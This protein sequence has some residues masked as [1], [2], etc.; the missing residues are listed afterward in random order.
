[1]SLLLIGA[2]LQTPLMARN[3]VL[4][5]LNVALVRSIN[6]S[7]K[8]LIVLR[9]AR[10]LLLPAQRQVGSR[11]DLD[12]VHVVERLLIGVLICV[13]KRIDMVVCPSARARIRMFPL[14]LLDHHIAQLRTKP[15]LV[16]LVR[17][18]MRVLVLEV[19]LQI[20][21]VQVAV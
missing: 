7:T 14:H 15:Q 3:R 5:C 20:V 21:H 18:R 12:E 13:I 9:R 17:E 1:M 19:V 11:H 16:D 4:M 2:T 6:R 10:S 8:Q